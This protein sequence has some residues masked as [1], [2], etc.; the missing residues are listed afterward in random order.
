M[1]PVQALEAT[2]LTF[3]G[4]IW[5]G[6]RR[7]IDGQTNPSS[8]SWPVIRSFFRPALISVVVA[9]IIE[10]PLCLF[11][12][13]FGAEPFAYYLSNNHAVA[14]ITAHMWRSIDWCYIFYVVSTQL[15]AV[16]LA[17]RPR[18][19]QTCYMYYRG[20]SHVR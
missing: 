18:W 10:V 3:I 13:F 14:K 17:T 1:V 19:Y 15:A 8:V 9:L 7:S 6:W 11:L 4:H 5:G 12:S 2:T 20:R 16:L